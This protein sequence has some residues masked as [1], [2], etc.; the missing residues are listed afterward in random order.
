MR[1]SLTIWFLTLLAGCVHT[2]YT[3]MLAPQTELVLTYDNR[4]V[5]RDGAQPI[6]RE[7]GFAGLVAHVDCVPSARHHARRARRH[8]RTATALAATG[9]T[10]GMASLGGLGGLALLDEDP[11]AAAAI[12]GSGLAV[13]IIGLTLS[14]VSRSHRVRAAGHAVDAVNEYNDALGRSG[15]RC[16]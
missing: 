4:L 12:V 8:G 16:R 10:L 13:G 7:P 3:P 5:I 6:A 9:G 15:Q 11:A 2:Q 14:M 1:K